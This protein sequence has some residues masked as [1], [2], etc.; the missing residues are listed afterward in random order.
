MGTTPRLQRTWV[1][2]RDRQCNQP[3]CPPVARLRGGR[4]YRVFQK[5][6]VSNRRRRHSLRKSLGCSAKKSRCGAVG[7]LARTQMKEKRNAAPPLKPLETTGCWRYCGFADGFNHEAGR[8]ER[9]TVRLQWSM[10]TVKD[11]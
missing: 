7:P 10:L 11:D 5:G 1:R 8:F 4:A 9:S 2:F 6:A 3:H